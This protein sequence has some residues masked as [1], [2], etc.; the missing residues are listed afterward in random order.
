[1]ID[2]FALRPCRAVAGEKQ[3]QRRGQAGKRWQS[4]TQ[5][6]FSF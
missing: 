4:I 3:E 6:R 5:Q 1:M 2:F